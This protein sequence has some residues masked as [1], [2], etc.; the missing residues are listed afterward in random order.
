MEKQLA[1]LG[2][3]MGEAYE[4]LLKQGLEFEISDLKATL[5]EGQIK[6]TF[7]LGLKKDMTIA[8]FRRLATEP[9]LALDI[10]SLK[11]DFSLPIKLIGENPQLL[12]PIFPGM[13]TGLFVKKG[14]NLIHHA[15]TRKGKLFLNGLELQLQ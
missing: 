2:H 14:N 12:Q 7:A 5:P 9:A 10:F 13:Q 4:K 11:S 15:E 3:Q 8:Q 1:G 6:G